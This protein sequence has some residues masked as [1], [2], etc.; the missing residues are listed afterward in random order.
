[1]STATSD[2][3]TT[4][5]TSAIDPHRSRAIS[6]GKQLTPE[7]QRARAEKMATMAAR[8]S[9]SAVGRHFGL[10][11]QR[12]SQLLRE[13][14]YRSDA[15]TRAQWRIVQQGGIEKRDAE[16]V[17]LF[18]D[19][20]S[21]QAIGRSVGISPS[22]VLAI[23]RRNGVSATSTIRCAHCGRLI[24][25]AANRRV[26]TGNIRF[27]ARPAC[28]LAYRN[29]RYAHESAF[30]AKVAGVNRR[31]RDRKLLRETLAPVACASCGRPLKRRIE[32]A[33]PSYCTQRACRTVRQR[34]RRRAERAEQQKE[35]TK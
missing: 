3:I 20:K 25:V 35:P 15:T 27:C 22:S 32:S 10:T 24:T 33:A 13:Y 21:T 19:G 14:G 4:S 30:R 8:M 23:L 7:E 9:L 18:H 29:W 26:A 5:A 31:W 1:M 16:V 11:R 34:E 12:V 17:K 2:T 28:R 6:R